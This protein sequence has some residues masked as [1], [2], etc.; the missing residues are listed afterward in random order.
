MEFNRWWERIGGYGGCSV[1]STVC[2]S[3]VCRSLVTGNPRGTWD[4]LCRAAV[5]SCVVTGKWL[6]SLSNT[7]YVESLSLCAS[8]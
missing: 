1:Q 4:A 7:E 8:L 5:L 6:S 3:F 2:G